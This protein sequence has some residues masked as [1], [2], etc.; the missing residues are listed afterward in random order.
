MT[1]MQPKWTKEQIREARKTDLEPILN[2]RGLRLHPLKNGNTL[3]EDY[4]VLVVKQHF[5]TWPDKN[6]AGNAI[7][8]FVKVLHLSFN[9]AMEII[10]CPAPHKMQ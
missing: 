4:P 3:V 8:F 7:D 9:Q 2:R 6:M 1:A 10:T 5:W